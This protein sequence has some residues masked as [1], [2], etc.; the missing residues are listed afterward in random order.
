MSLNDQFRQLTSEMAIDNLMPAH[1]AMQAAEFLIRRTAARPAH[2][3]LLCDDDND[4]SEPQ[5]HANSRVH[6]VSLPMSIF[7]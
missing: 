1:T 6:I 5:P 4:L 7:Q 2:C 3:R